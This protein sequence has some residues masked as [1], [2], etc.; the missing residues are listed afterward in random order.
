MFPDYRHSLVNISA[1]VL[2][3]FGVE[4]SHP[5]LPE[6]DALLAYP[7]RNVVILLLDGMGDGAVRDLLAPEGFFNR[8]RQG[9]V[10]SVFPP[11]TTAATLSLMTGKTPCETGWLGWKQ[12]FPALDR[13]VVPFTN[14][15]YYTGERIAT[16]HAARTFLYGSYIFDAVDRA[17]MGRAYHVSPFGTTRADTWEALTRHIRMLCAQAGRKLIYAYWEQPDNIMHKTGSHSE[18]TKAELRMLETAVEALCGA[19]KDTLLI[20]TADHGHRDT[21]YHN[22]DDYPEIRQMLVRPPALESR[23]CA[24]YVREAD[25]ARFPA[26]FR[27]V[28]PS[29]FRL[30]S[31]AEVLQNGMFGTGEHHPLFEAF[32]G[33]FLA[34]SVAEYG[35]VYDARCRQF[36]SNHGGLTPDE[37]QVPFIVVRR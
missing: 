28:F 4:A 8:H 10:S 13:I 36:C 6:L 25:R 30:F 24:F 23:A 34:V 17:G 37:M 15:D 16:C 2:R 5:T 31:K 12:Y 20:V 32:I 33:D 14:T 27:R 9:A 1:S 21:V 35:I 11:T 26:V 3:A 7:Y 22:L 29:G 19:L 18:Q